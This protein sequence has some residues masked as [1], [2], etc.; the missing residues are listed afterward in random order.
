MTQAPG[1][2]TGSFVTKAKAMLVIPALL[3][4]AQ[5]KGSEPKSTDLK[6]YLGG[7]R[8]LSPAGNNS[9]TEK[10]MGAS[11]VKPAERL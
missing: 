2:T 9:D 7:Y 6:A 3:G 8:S 4:A 11:D 10:Y 1:S 5:T